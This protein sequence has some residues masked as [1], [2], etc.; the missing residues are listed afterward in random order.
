MLLTDLA[1]VTSSPCYVMDSFNTIV[2]LYARIIRI[3]VSSQN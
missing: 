3:V 1:W 2:S